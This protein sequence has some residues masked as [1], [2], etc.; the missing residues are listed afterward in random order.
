VTFLSGWRLLLLIVPLALVATY[1]ALQR[2]RP[3]YVVRFT[4]VDLLA[5]VAPRR[6]GWQRHVAA[7]LLVAAVAALVVGLAR[8]ALT[9]RTPRQQATV[10]VTIDTS[11]SMAATDVSPTRLDAAKAQ[12]RTFVTRLPSGIK[13]GVVQ[14]ATA[15]SVVAAPTTD[16]STVLAAIDGLQEGEGT[17][18]GDA[19]DLALQAIKSLPVAANG[20]PAPAVI[21]LLSDGSPTVTSTDGSPVA[22]ADSAA[23]AAGAAGVPIDTIALG[24]AEGTVTVQGRTIPAPSDPQTMA[25][26][27]SDSR[28]STFTATDRHELQRVYDSIGRAVGYEVHKHDITA[29]FT[30]IGLLLVTAAAAAALVWTQRLA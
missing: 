2:M 10:M 20:K 8:P 26:L 13:V 18:T 6:S 30:G 9:S 22:A 19:I 7:A 14:F 24:T 21:V 27:A 29:W 28:G 1:M 25:Q 4:D 17:A 3:R 5:S 16:R 11:A 15:A 12:A 23:Q